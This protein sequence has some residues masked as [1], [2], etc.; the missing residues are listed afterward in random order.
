VIDRISSGHD[1]LDSV[2][3][4][5]LPANGINLILGSP[6]T[7]KTILAQQYVFFNASVERPA[8][9]LSTVSEPFEKL[10]RYAQTLDFFDRSAVGRSVFYEDMSGPLAA[11]GLPGVLE[12]IDR[13]IKAHPSGVMVIDSF[14]ALTAYAPDPRGFR[15]FVHELA[16]RLSALPISSFWVGEYGTKELADAPEFAVGDA[17]IA[18]STLRVGERETR[19]LQVLKIR[20]SAF[21]PGSHAYRISEK[22]VDVFPRLA[23]PAAPAEYALTGKRTSSGIP[24]LD[25]M[26]TDGFVAGSSTLVA[27]PSG[28]GKTVMGLH[29]VIH[30]ARQGEPGVIA[31]FQENPSQLERIASGFGWSIREEGVELMY[32]APVDLYVDEWVYD[33]LATVER[34]NA[35]RVL[36]DSLTDLEFASPDRSRF[37]EY[38]Y[39]L[40]QRCARAEVSLYMTTEVATLFEVSSLSEFGISHASDN[41]LL[42]QYVRGASQLTR[43]VTVLKTRASSHQPGIREYTITSDGITLGPSLEVGPGP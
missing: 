22:G 17:I 24:L 38:I 14:K 35:R 43:A 30:G 15:Q 36:I 37:R 11:D 7:G 16:G 2:L 9:F 33:L 31:T 34:S 20:G 18:L 4:G 32:R 1:R 41:V 29:F 28:I 21:A 8:L 40:T 23:D 10:V 42:L 39:S 19:L 13:L 12:E 3:G 26:L 5:G 6:G 25:E 27:G